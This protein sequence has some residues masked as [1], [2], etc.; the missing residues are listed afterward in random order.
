M[1]NTRTKTLLQ[2]VLPAILTNTCIFLF[3][4]ID[5]IFVGNGVD[6]NALGA[7]NIAMP[8]VMIVTVLNML[9]SIGGVT[10]TA[11]RLGRHEKEGAN[12]AFMHALTANLT[13]AIIITITS[14]SIIFC[15]S[16]A[17]S[18]LMAHTPVPRQA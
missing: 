9:T 3:T 5:G 8:F 11:I 10:I 2:Y 12:Q 17:I 15:I 4:I 6:S 13:V 18:S 14:Q 16:S 7:V 1:K